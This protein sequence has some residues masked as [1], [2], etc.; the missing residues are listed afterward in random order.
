MGEL[1]ED[2]VEMATWHPER[3]PHRLLLPHPI[4]PAAALRLD[5]VVLAAARKH[6]AHKLTLALHSAE[7]GPG[8]VGLTLAILERIYTGA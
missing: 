6:R 4:P 3:S 2:L 8:G 7:P 5:R 1:A